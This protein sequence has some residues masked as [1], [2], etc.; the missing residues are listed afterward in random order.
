MNREVCNRAPLTGA[1]A[2]VEYYSTNFELFSCVRVE[3]R[4][5]QRDLMIATEI[6]A[7]SH[8]EEDDPFQASWHPTKGRDYKLPCSCLSPTPKP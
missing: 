3:P 7:L 8:R 5:I 1:R 6:I 2:R 4:P